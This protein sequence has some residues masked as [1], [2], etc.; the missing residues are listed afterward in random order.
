MCSGLPNKIIATVALVERAARVDLAYLRNRITVENLT[1]R[2]RLCG[3]HLSLGRNAAGFF[4][5]RFFHR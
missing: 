5:E 4:L 3:L 1:T 2:P